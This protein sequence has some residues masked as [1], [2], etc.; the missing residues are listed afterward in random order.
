MSS[1]T[2]IF[3]NVYSYRRPSGIPS[4]IMSKCDID[5]DNAM[6]HDEFIECYKDKSTHVNISQVF[7]ELDTN[8]DKFISIKEIDEDE[9]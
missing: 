2:D 9:D 5:A 8:N 6:S 4:A 7:Y 1:K 3:N